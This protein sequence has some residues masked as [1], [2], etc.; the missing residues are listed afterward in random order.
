MLGLTGL[1]CCELRNDT[2][3]VGSEITNFF[4]PSK[5][6]PYLEHSSHSDP[7]Y[8]A[9]AESPPFCSTAMMQCDATC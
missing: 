9:A 8:H 7:I 5:S 2:L 4:T 1:H 3:A 6:G